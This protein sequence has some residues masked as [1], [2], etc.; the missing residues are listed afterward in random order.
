MFERYNKGI[1]AGGDYFEVDESFMCVL[2]I[3]VPIRKKYTLRKMRITG[4]SGFE[5][6]HLFGYFVSALSFLCHEVIKVLN[7]REEIMA[8]S[9]N[10]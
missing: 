8:L 2:S 7:S 6:Q 9:A 10:P 3:K 4:K 5:N 1:A